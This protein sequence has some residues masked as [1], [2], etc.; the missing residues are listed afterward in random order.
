MNYTETLFEVPF[1]HMPESEI[2]WESAAG[3]NAKK[4]LILCHADALGQHLPYLKQIFQGVGMDIDTDAHRIGLKPDTSYL[5]LSDRRMKTYR[6]C[7]LFGIDP[8]RIGL[9]RSTSRTYDVL[10]FETLTCIIAPPLSVISL[11]PKDE[12]IILF[13][14]LKDL[15]MP[16]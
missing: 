13:R 8:V 6:H 4:I 9:P 5:L 16:N 3:D 7:F 11:Q 15:F 14:I 1:Y 2:T 12:K 10:T